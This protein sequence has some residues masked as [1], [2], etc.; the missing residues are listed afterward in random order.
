MKDLFV[1]IDLLGNHIGFEK[2]GSHI[3]K[4][5]FGAILSSTVILTSIVVG[6]MFGKEIYERKA[7]SVNYSKEFINQSQI[8]YK[9]FP[10][11]IN[12]NYPNGKAL[13]KNEFNSLMSFKFLFFNLTKSEPFD[14]SYK[15][16][17]CIETDL[18][19]YQDYFKKLKCDSNN[20]PC[21]CIKEFGN[22]SFFNKHGNPDASF[23]HIEAYSCTEN[24]HPE[25]NQILNNIMI[26]FFI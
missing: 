17:D 6:F 3:N 12:V 24:C 20:N 13:S 11:I 21:F 10:F 7:P 5:L 4:S 25:I 2:N 16:V 15:L 23:W 14:E 1:K 18:P 22:L 8:F 19:A 9:D 26:N